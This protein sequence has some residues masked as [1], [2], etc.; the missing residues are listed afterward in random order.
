MDSMNR[1]STVKKQDAFSTG[2]FLPVKTSLGTTPADPKDDKTHSYVYRYNLPLSADG[3]GT[4]DVTKAIAR[5]SALDFFYPHSLL[6]DGGVT[7]TDALNT[8]KMKRDVFL[9]AFAAVQALDHTDKWS[10]YQIAGIHGLP[11]EPYDNV[12]SE[13][14][15]PKNPEWW[16]GYCHHGSPLFPTWHRPH[17]MLL[18]QSIIRQAKLFATTLS[19]KAEKDAVLALADDLRFPYWD[20]ANQSTRLLGLPEVFMTTDVA[21]LYPWKSI[22]DTTIPNPLKSFVLPVNL[23]KVF[24]SSDVYNPTA[25]PHYKVPPTG[26]IFTPMNYPTVRHV[27]EAY[28]SQPDKLNVTLIRS[29]NSTLVEGV[30][31]VFQHNQWLPFSN[32][33]WSEETHGDGSQ[34]GHYSSIELVH[35]SVHGYVGGSGGH[36]AHL[37]VAAFDPIFFFHHCNVD[38]LVALWQYCYPN[39]WIPSEALQLNNDGTYTQHPES[40]VNEN[41]P[42]TPFR[43]SASDANKFAT[44]NDVRLVD[45]DCGYSYPEILQARKEGWT[46]AQM[47]DYV[48]KLYDPPENY[49]HKWL[50]NVER[51]VKRAFNG[52]FSIRV[53]IAKPD[54][55]A[56]TSIN[57]PNFA[58]DI[59]IFAR[60][61]GVRCANCE[62]KQCMRASLD[63]TKTMVRLGIT[64]APRQSAADDPF[65]PSS[66]GPSNPLSAAGSIRLV[67]VDMQG[68]QLDPSSALGNWEGPKVSLYYQ[69]GIARESVNEVL[70]QSDVDVGPQ[71]L[72]KFALTAP[73]LSI[74]GVAD[75]AAS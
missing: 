61:N 64:T 32:H 71:T 1:D 8:M 2:I 74:A 43:V 5:E 31:A 14:W 41:T 45:A 16:G 34:Y 6:S 69:K 65:A 17:V 58:G 42:L 56:T 50:L 4:V 49:L 33:Y 47:L 7:S 21:L 30:H 20:S 53:F 35:D 24:S 72:N 54:A 12:E 60:A 57:I 11:H 18:E 40:E 44:S 63:L 29:A 48:M 28:Q 55:D 23:G 70:V 66:R 10:Y 51:I 36:L 19:E 46:P 62:Q 27:N 13:D 9:M 75:A 22:S 38:R 37:E 3:N 39:S 59:P 73:Q 26:T 67:F 68:R 15:D 25:K 52:P